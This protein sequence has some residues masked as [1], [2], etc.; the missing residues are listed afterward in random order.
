MQTGISPLFRNRGLVPIGCALL[1]FGG[2]AGCQQGQPSAAPPQ[3]LA[4]PVS[5]P[6]QRQV[7]DYVDYTGQTD[8][9]E[10]VGLRA[11]V[12]GYLTKINFT[13][14]AEVKKD[15][16]L[17]VIDPRPYQDQVDQAKAQLALNQ[18][19]LQLARVTYN[20]DRMVGASGVSQQQLDQDLA[21][22]NQSQAQ[23]RTAQAALAAAQLNLDFTQVKSPIAGK[24]SRYY[25]TVGNLVIA[26]STLLTTVVSLDP[27]YVYFNIDEAT[28]LRIRRAI[29]T[30][31][32][33]R[34]SSQGH[35]PVFMGLQGEDGYPHEGTLNFLNNAVNPSTGTI[36]AQGVFPNPLPPNGT[37]LL[38][39]GMYVRIRLPI[40]QPQPAL[41]VIDRAVGSDQGLSF[42]YIVDSNHVVQYRRVTTG[43]L[44]EDGLRVISGGL[45]PT[46]WVVV[47]AIQQVRP[48]MQVQAVET[49]MP[50]IPVAAEAPSAT[51]P[52]PQPPPPGAN[53]TQP[54]AAGPATGKTP[55]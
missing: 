13:Q 41:L 9:V 37:R 53:P 12:T 20:R 26:N 11:Q 21:A 15:Q 38:S 47:G 25:I 27:M 24:T 23:V 29:N 52:G 10:A 18:A 14:G 17:F 32:I 36:A 8:A 22:V 44:Q 31:K 45:Q 54:P 7:T 34:P 42:V 1:L 19:T 35:V 28:L 40:G 6:V 2:L 48:R 43:P 39:P 51:N 30:G 16:V 49:P 46:D 50:T 33:K 55:R 4:V 5:Q 3:P